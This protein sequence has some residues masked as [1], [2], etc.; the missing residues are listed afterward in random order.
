MAIFDTI[1]EMTGGSS[2][3]APLDLIVSLGINAGVT[4]IACQNDSFRVGIKM[5]GEIPAYA[6]FRFIGGVGAGIVA[7]LLGPASFMG[8]RAAHDLAT[9]LLG[10]YVSTEMC[11]ANALK[12]MEQAGEEEGS[13]NYLLGAD[14]WDD[15]GDDD[16]MFAAEEMEEEFAAW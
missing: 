13:E 5:G 3:Y 4:H 1:T 2:E 8:K 9:G 10:S 16:D 12:R 7:Q 14:D 15:F 6:D 11:R